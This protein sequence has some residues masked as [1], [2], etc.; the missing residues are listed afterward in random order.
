MKK[1]LKYIFIIIGLLLASVLIYQLAIKFM[2]DIRMF[3]NSKSVES[4]AILQKSVRSHKASTGILLILLTSVMSAIPG[5]PTSVVGVIVGVCYGPLIGSIMNIIGNSLGNIGS[6]YLMHKFKFMD[7]SKASNHWVQTLSNAKHPNISITVA[8]M[9]PIIPSFLVNFTATLLNIKFT[10][11]IWMTLV[12]SIP[13]SILYAFG[14]D[15]LFKGNET[16]AVLLIASVGILIAFILL[17][18][19]DRKQK[20]NTKIKA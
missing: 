8:Y 10:Q 9:I 3:V 1:Q 14:G 11:L 5:I 20:E 19:K 13:S 7:K 16:R 18:K 4:R 12:G 6:F 17:I 15:A 2:P